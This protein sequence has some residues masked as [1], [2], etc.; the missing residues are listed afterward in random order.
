MCVR[1][2]ACVFVCVCVSACMRVCVFG[3]D[4][5]QSDTMHLFI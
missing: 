2:H 1:V 3:N 4:I 5:G